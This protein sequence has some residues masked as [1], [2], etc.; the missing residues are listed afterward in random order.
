MVMNIILKRKLCVIGIHDWARTVYVVPSELSDDGEA[1][2]RIAC[3]NCPETRK[4]ASF[5]DIT[6]F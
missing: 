1:H 3:V 2:M 5:K 4:Y 6:E